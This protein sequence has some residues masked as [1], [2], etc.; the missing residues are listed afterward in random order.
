MGSCQPAEIGPLSWLLLMSRYWR[1]EEAQV[2]WQ[3]NRVC[4][5][6]HTRDDRSTDQQ[7]LHPGTP[8]VFLGAGVGEIFYAVCTHP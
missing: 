5:K 3:Q 7:P 1:A 6:P 8:V 4:A 2:R